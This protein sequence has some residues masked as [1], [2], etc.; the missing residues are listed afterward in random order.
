MG[1]I[2]VGPSADADPKLVSYLRANRGQA[3][4]LVATLSSG[5]ASPI[6]L[7]TGEPVMSL[8][9]FGADRILTNDQ[10]AERVARGEVRFFLLP[11]AMTSDGQATSSDDEPL[12]DNAGWVQEHCRPVPSKLWQSTPSQSDDKGLGGMLDGQT[13]YDCG[14]TAR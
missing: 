5:D 8:G 13:L 2:G 6:I 10:L 1:I 12:H 9:G 7:A 4:F 3:K 14:Q 11:T